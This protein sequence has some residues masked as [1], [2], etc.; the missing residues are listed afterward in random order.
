MEFY[1]LAWFKPCLP[2]NVSSFVTL[3]DGVSCSRS[4]FSLRLFSVV[5]RH[6]TFLAYSIYYILC[7]KIAAT[8]W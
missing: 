7:I 1:W 8:L 5:Q 3:I 4:G 2:L 6:A